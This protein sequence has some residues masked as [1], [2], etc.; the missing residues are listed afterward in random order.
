MILLSVS[1]NVDYW[2]NLMAVYE[3]SWHEPKIIHRFTGIGKWVLK[4][5]KWRPLLILQE[6]PFDLL[7]EKVPYQRGCSQFLI[8]SNKCYSSI[9]E[10]ILHIRWEILLPLHWV[11]LSRYPM[12][13]SSPTPQSLQPTR[14][15]SKFPSHRAYPKNNPSKTFFPN[16]WILDWY[17]AE[18]GWYSTSEPN[19]MIVFKTVLQ[20][21]FQ[22]AS[23]NQ[24]INLWRFADK[25]NIP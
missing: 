12:R 23:S 13:P 7:L 18:I 15:P 9:C 11:F 4:W 2:F 25:C 17:F 14:H 22:K 5:W 24:K 20:N 1:K 19:G 10:L 3:V 8:W 21:V 6:N 16:W